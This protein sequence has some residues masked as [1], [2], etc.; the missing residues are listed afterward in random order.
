M[1]IYNFIDKFLSIF[2]IVRLSK[3]QYLEKELSYLKLFYLDNLTA[4]EKIIN[5][6]Q[7]EN[8]L[9]KISNKIPKK[10]DFDKNNYLKDLQK[11]LKEV[12]T[13]EKQKLQAWS[14]RVR[15]VGKCDICNTTK[16]LTA[17]HLWDKHTHPSL[18]YQDENG[19][20]LC[21]K[22]HNKFHTTYTQASQTTPHQY[23]IFK[24][25]MKNTLNML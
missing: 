1:K 24:T 12:K 7:E 10:L 13:L 11:A 5:K 6:L 20:C 3:Y 2:K 8:K 18:A 22:C 14:K 9:L 19:V 23:E 4:K 25:K 21:N 17:H 16:H 15:T